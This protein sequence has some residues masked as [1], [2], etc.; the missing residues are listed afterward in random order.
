MGMVVSPSVRADLRIRNVRYGLSLVGA[1]LT[2]AVAEALQFLDFSGNGALPWLARAAV[3]LVIGA[4]GSLRKPSISKAALT[5]LA[6]I[7][8]AAVGA[9]LLVDPAV[10]AIPEVVAPLALVDALALMA[11][12]TLTVFATRS[13]E[14]VGDD[15]EPGPYGGPVDV[16]QEPAAD[17]TELW[18][19]VI[20]CLVGLALFAYGWVVGSHHAAGYALVGV[21]AVAILVSLFFRR[22]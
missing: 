1:A 6:G 4:S 14:Y 9:W 3:L 18:L 22:L 13:R 15:R 20:G 19:R 5:F 17:Y 10:M 21:G 11:W 8:A 7:L 12:A 16:R 2:G